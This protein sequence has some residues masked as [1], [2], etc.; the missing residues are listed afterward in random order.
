VA[1]QNRTKRAIREGK[2]VLGLYSDTLDPSLVELMAKA[3]LDFV[4]LDTEHNAYGLDRCTECV[5]AAEAWGITPLVRVYENSPRL[6]NKA[7]EIGAQGVVVPHVDTPELARLAVAAT[8]YPPEGIRGVH[9]STRAAGYASGPEEWDRAWRAANEDLMVILQPLESE[10]GIANLDQ[11]ASIPGI[12]LIG[13][14]I[15]DLSQV[16]GAPLRASDPRVRAVREQARAICR[17][18][19]VANYALI[20]G[21]DDLTAWYAEGVRVF[22]CGSDVG[23]FQQSCARLVDGLRESIG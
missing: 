2:L 9:P 15:G 10:Q 5:R 7:L 19:G 13:L 16:L 11:I 8:R 3:G 21:V 4:I 6:I 18:R 23:I 22:V 17:Q 1:R 14:G 20:R 12:D